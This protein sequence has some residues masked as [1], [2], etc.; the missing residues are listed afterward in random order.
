V[1]LFKWV[2]ENDIE[3]K[4]LICQR[5]CCSPELPEYLVLW[6]TDS[7]SNGAFAEM[8]RICADNWQRMRSQRIAP[9]SDPRATLKSE[10]RECAAELKVNSREVRYGRP[11][12]RTRSLHAAASAALERLGRQGNHDVD[13]CLEIARC[14]EDDLNVDAASTYNTV[15]NPRHGSSGSRQA[16]TPR[17][18]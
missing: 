16:S 10:F 17:T 7:T 3:P 9:Q 12:C 11:T 1:P 14:D 5:L 8:P 15:M 13:V 4:C 2:S 6:V 18:R